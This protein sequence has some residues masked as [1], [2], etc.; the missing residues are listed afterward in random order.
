MTLHK[1]AVMAG[2]SILVSSLAGL[3]ILHSITDNVL[4]V[5]LWVFA[6]RVNET[7]FM[8]LNAT[9]V[10]VASLLPGPMVAVRVSELASRAIVK[11]GN[12]SASLG[13]GEERL[14]ECRGPCL[15]EVTVEV[16]RKPVR[17]TMAGD[18]AVINIEAARVRPVVGSFALNSLR[19]MV[20]V[21]AALLAYGIIWGRRV[22]SWRTA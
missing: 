18:A 11:A 3:G 17:L 13:P 21:G 9:N 20:A 1:L 8:P 15:V 16:S 6:V 14:I 7:H 4:P 2:V 5:K 19:L 12:S 10:S 22:A